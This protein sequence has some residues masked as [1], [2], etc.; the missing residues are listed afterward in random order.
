MADEAQKANAR[1][2][3]YSSARHCKVN[4]WTPGMWVKR[5]KDTDEASALPER[6]LW[7]IVD[8]VWGT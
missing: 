3:L 6:E 2:A 8:M 7:A 5:A 4:S 1:R